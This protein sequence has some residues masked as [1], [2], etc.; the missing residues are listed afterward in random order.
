L[1]AAITVRSADVRERLAHTIGANGKS[2]MGFVG[3]GSMGGAIAHR[4]IGFENT[5]LV[6]YDTNLAAAEP[7]LRQGAILADSPREVGVRAE[8]IFSCLPTN[9][10]HQPR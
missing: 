7:L 8:L 2:V 5:G 4:L 3:I 1:K 6:V 10:V 9:E